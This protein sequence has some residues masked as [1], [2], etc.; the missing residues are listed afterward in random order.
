VNSAEVHQSQSERALAKG[1]AD[2]KNRAQAHSLLGW[3]VRASLSLLGCL[4]VKV[5][6]G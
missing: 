3:W 4:V 5:L 2:R 1:Q 6:L